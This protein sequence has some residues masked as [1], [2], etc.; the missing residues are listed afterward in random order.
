MYIIMPNTVIIVLILCVFGVILSVFSSVRPFCFKWKHDETSIITIDACDGVDDRWVCTLH[1]NILQVIAQALR[2][3][4]PDPPAEQ[5][6]LGTP[7]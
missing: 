1:S 5:H 4:D 7:N 3:T 6:N 2:V